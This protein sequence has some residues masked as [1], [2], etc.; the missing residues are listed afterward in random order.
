MRQKAILSAI[1]T[2]N[3]DGKAKRI[4]LEG[5]VPSPINPPSG[6]AFHPR[7]PL[8]T[9]ICKEKTPELENISEAGQKS[10]CFHNDQ[11]KEKYKNNSKFAEIIL[12]TLLRKLCLYI[13]GCFKKMLYL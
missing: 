10:A 2:I 11:S 9:D 1:P 4:I 5:D 13:A 8:A 3:Q 12:I 6:C 7:C